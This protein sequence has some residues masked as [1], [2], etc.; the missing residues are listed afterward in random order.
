M[1]V[2]PG[3][4]RP[5]R[6]A[7]VRFGSVEEAKW[8]VETAASARCSENRRGFHGRLVGRPWVCQLPSPLLAY[9]MVFRVHLR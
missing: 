2:L 7:M 8:V 5:D 6:A 1:Q 3:E 4:G 9:E